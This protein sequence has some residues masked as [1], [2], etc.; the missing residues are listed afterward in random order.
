MIVL[1]E[2]EERNMGS[3]NELECEEEGIEID[4]GRETEDGSDYLRERLMLF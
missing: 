1:S 4:V 3:E 2:I